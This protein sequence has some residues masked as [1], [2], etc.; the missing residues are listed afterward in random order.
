MS[1]EQ[2]A[3]RTAHE[4]LRL[5][6]FSSLGILLTQT[7]SHCPSYT[8]KL[9]APGKLRPRPYLLVNRES[10]NTKPNVGFGEYIHLGKDEQQASK[11]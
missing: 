11:P 2:T 10:R 5:S 3:H 7:L 4:D 6:I 1:Q 8:T 9:L